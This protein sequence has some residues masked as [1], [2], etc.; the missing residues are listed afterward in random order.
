MIGVMKKRNVPSIVRFLDVESS[1]INDWSN[2]ID[3][4]DRGSTLNLD[5]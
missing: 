5:S 3:E 4:W 1:Q 2:S